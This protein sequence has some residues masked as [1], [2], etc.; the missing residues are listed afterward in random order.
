M[1]RCMLFAKKTLWLFLIAAMA[2]LLVGSGGPASADAEKTYIE[3]IFDSS[4]SMNEEAERNKSRMDVA[5]EVM[6][7]LIRNLEDR[8]GLEVGLR[9]Y[10]A[11]NTQCD[12]SVL[13]QNF[14]PVAQVREKIIKI[15]R[16][17]QPRGKTPIAY[18]L[19]LAA[20]DFPSK[21]S[22]NIIVLITDGEESCGG[23]PCVVSAALQAEGIIYK[24]YVVG[25]AMTQAQ[26]ARVR[27]I[28]TY[29]SAKDRKS[30]S[31]ALGTIMKEVVEVPEVRP[32]NLQAKVT[33]R[34]S[35]VTAD[36][37]LELVR[38]GS[39]VASYGTGSQV[40]RYSGDPGKV[41]LKVTYLGSV[42]VEKTVA[43]ILLEQGQ[44]TAV[45]V[46][47][48]DLLGTLRAKVK[49][50]SRDVTA[51]AEASARD[52]RHEVSL[53]PRGDV[54]AAVIPAGFYGV[55]AVYQ[56]HRS[57]LAEVDVKAGEITDVTLTVDVPGKLVLV[58]TFDGKLVQT[59]RVRAWY[60]DSAG[61]EAGFADENGKLTASVKAGA[62]EIH[63]EYLGTPPQVRRLDRV[64]V[65]AGE[66]KQIP[67]PFA[68]EG[69]LR[70]KLTAD[71]RPHTAGDPRV[72]VYK[73]G[74][75]FDSD[76][77]IADLEQ[78]AQAIYEGQLRYGKY[79]LRI[80]RLGAGYQDEEILDV[81]VIG[82]EVTERIIEV[83][84]AGKLQVRLSSDGRP[85]TAGDP[86]VMVYKA[87]AGFDS[88]AWIVD[89]EQVARAVYEGVLKAG[90]Y[91]LKIFRLGD[92][93]SDK[94]VLGI[95]V[96]GGVATQ[97]TI[98]LGGL[99]KLRLRLTSGGKPHEAY[100]AR[101]MVYEA[102]AE[103]DG[104][105]WVADLEETSLG[106]WESELKSG[107]YDLKIFNL[108]AGYEDVELYGVNVE[109][110]VVTQKA[111]ELG[112]QGKLRL[113][114]TS[115]GKPHEAY[116]ARVMVYE[117]GAEFDGD[118]W[119]A[120]LEETSLGV[121]ESELKS[122]AYDILMINLGEGFS[123]Q[124][125]YGI[126]VAGGSI[127]ER[128][129]ELGGIGQIQVDLVGAE[130]YD[131]L[132]VM[133]FTVG[134]F[135]QWGEYDTYVCDLE[136]DDRRGIWHAEVREG[137]YQLQITEGH[138]EQRVEIIVEPGTITRKGIVLDL[139]ED[140]E[141][142]EQWGEDADWQW[143]WQVEEDW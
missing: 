137:R 113:R 33:Y 89:L 93:F 47:L 35:D 87:G 115:G 15:V 10:G 109:G 16:D 81:E 8:P 66:I 63:C 46:K 45:T 57:Q 34:D 141:A 62:Y 28:G 27:C 74:A 4:F 114:L 52:N 39:K 101:V 29:Y 94:E 88:D 100:Y 108:G 96:K 5:K 126:D 112:G 97:K 103:F 32:A 138:A 1:I 24:P 37:R 84:A 30:L 104:D 65:A 41:D 128:T 82:G 86:R 78:A 130:R 80:V 118:A 140:W 59:D 55:Q 2:T 91:D 125:L 14:G 132:R 72:M 18:S 43:G 136:Y 23:N 120:D 49:A 107:V 36:C 53:S 38:D 25:F 50:G 122:G 12:D 99:G 56:G 106:V 90:E 143:E 69:K 139:R 142:Y 31:E 92:G 135:S 73:A 40:F 61:N 13:M 133:L 102:G 77:W 121:W 117:A 51:Q 64:E 71:G 3:F 134:E 111:I 70:V 131:W 6:I 7:D 68:A 123:E 85:H 58:P 67:V 42:T 76:A 48:D 95:E 110:G 129:I 98:E 75:G 119:V 124:Q 60:I 26:E 20:L 127:T 9:V 17:L 105:A 11:R 21:E 79:D 83:G 54:L 19:E 44:T 116:Y 22:R